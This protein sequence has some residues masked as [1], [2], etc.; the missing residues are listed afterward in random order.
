MNLPVIQSTPK[1]NTPATEKYDVGE[2]LRRCCF[3]ILLRGDFVI[4]LY[5]YEVSV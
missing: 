1:D 3:D 5:V 4:E 2:M